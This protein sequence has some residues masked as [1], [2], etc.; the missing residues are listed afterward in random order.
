M[1]GKTVLIIDDDTDLLHLASHVFQKVGAQVITASNEMEGISKL[2]T[3]HPNLIILD[4][5]LPQAN[6]FEICRSI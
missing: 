5:I 6:G 1:I 2:F 3:Y 4:V